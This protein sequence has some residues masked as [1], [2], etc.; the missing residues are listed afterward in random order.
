MDDAEKEKLLMKLNKINGVIDEKIIFVTGEIENQNKLIEDNKIQLQNTTLDIV[1][2]ETDSNEMKKQSGIISVQLAGI[3]N[4]INELS[5]QIRENEYEIQSLK[6]KI[7]DQ[8]PDPKAWISGTVFTNPAV[9]FREISKLLNNNIQE[10]KNKISR[11][12]N[13]VNTEISKKN[14]HITK[15]NECDSTIHQI[16]VKLQRL[17]IQRADLENKLKD[18]GI[19]KTNN[20]NFKLELQSSNSQCKLI[21][22][23]VK[24]GKELLDIGI[25]L[26][27]EIEEKIKTLF[28]SK[29]LALSF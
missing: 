13:E 14:S 24:Q 17:Q 8:R 4:Q 19:Q 6:D 9:A 23:S 18:L 21:I 11:L 5:K 16:D 1:K 2:N 12:S 3:E 25:N 26:V 22:E 20:E 10:C 28:S 27:I 7:E 15:K 29:G